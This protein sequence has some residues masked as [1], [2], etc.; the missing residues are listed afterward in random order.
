MERI[1]IVVEGWD[2]YKLLDSGNNRKLELFEDLIIDRPEIQALW[3]KTNNI[4][5]WAQSDAQFLWVEKGERWKKS[6]KTKDSWNISFEDIKMKLS[7]K[8]FK[9]VGIFPEH[10]DQWIEIIKIGK[11]NKNIKM[12]N[13]FGY[14]GA[15]SIAGAIA[16]ISVTHVDASKQTI[17]SL[18]ENIE[19]SGLSKDSIRIICEDA[20]RYT[21]RLIER[22]EKFEI[23]IMDPPAFGRGPKGEIWK[24]EDSLAEL[25]E[26]IPKILSEKAQM[27]I[28]NGYASGYSARTF[29]ELTKRFFN[30]K[31]GTISYGDI[32]IKQ[33]NSDKI[34][35]TGIYTK[36][37]KKK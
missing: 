13:L 32:G 24:V 6:Q 27:F 1:D 33:N 8:G 25:V 20:L 18:K 9:H 23:I 29:G 26:L 11:N 22:G 10:K 34:L 30:E 28:L 3:K 21:K 12:L 16:G 14:T 36:W 4:D 35:T 17:N 19:L 31:E 37:K 2:K 15:A 5:L 7:F